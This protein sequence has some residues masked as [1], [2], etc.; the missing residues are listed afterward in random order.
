MTCRNGN[1]AEFLNGFSKRN[2]A[3]CGIVCI[4]DFIF[5]LYAHIFDFRLRVV[6]EST[7]L[8]SFLQNKTRVICM[9]VN[10]NYF[11]VID[12][13]NAVA[14]SF[15]VS[16]QLQRIGIG[17]IFSDD[18]FSAVSKADILVK[19]AYSGSE[20]FSGSV[21]LRKVPKAD[22]PSDS[23]ASSS[24]GSICWSEATVARMPVASYRNT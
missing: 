15:K 4:S 12:N 16:T 2:T 21:T 1:E 17:F 6:Y 10:L 24:E 3:V 14:D 8:D 20:G 5:V 9:N 19:F 22:S 11:V 13:D 7:E 23:E 18:K